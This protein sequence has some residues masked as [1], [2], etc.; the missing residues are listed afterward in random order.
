MVENKPEFVEADE[1]EIIFQDYSKVHFYLEIMF[2]FNF[3]MHILT[4]KKISF[5][6]NQKAQRSDF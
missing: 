3:Q 5:Q 2:D 1:G 4:K 6:I